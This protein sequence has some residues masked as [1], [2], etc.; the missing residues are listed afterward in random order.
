LGQPTLGAELAVTADPQVRMKGC[1][2]VVVNPPWGFAEEVQA[3]LPVLANILAIDGGA[4][5][6]WAWLVPER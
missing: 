5:S 1:G 4:T 2:L 3:V 6:R